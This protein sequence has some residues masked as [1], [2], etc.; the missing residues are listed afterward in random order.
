MIKKSSEKKL[1][2]YI[3]AGLPTLSASVEIAR[4]AISAGAGIIELGVP[5]S[6]PTADGTTI[7]RASQKALERGIDLSK[8]FSIA[9]KLKNDGADVYLMS[10]LN[11]LTAYG[12]KRLDDDTISA[13][14][15]GF[16]IPDL[17]PDSAESMRRKGLS[18]PEKIVYLAAPNTP[19]DRLKKIAAA[20]RGFVYAVSLFGVTGA[21]R[22]TAPR[23][24]AKFLEK[25]RALSAGKPVLAGFGVSSPARAAAL[26]EFADGVIIGSAVMEII[27]NTPARRAPKAVGDFVAACKK[28]IKKKRS[29]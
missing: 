14:V 16:I 25:L 2:I 1:A 9:R 21:R 13:D 4:A 29:H 19:A 27:E 10:Y 17:T 7:Q 18:L 20:S 23:P 15:S 11:P 24:P 12:A 3:T 28:A 6:D 5:F 26:A 8:T 22:Q